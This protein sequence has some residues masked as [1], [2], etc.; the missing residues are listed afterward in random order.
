MNAGGVGG[1]RGEGECGG[2]VMELTHPV[3]DEFA[4]KVGQKPEVFLL[5]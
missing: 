3:N 5:L 1:G 4:S 2:N